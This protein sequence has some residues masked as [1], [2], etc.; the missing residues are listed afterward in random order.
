LY[1]DQRQGAE[2]VSSA[3]SLVP[4]EGDDWRQRSLESREVL[5]G[6][7]RRL[8]V[9]EAV[10]VGPN[11]RLLVWRWYSI[12]GSRTASPVWAKVIETREKLLFRRPL[13][14]G[15]LAFTEGNDEELGRERLEEFLVEGL[16]VIA[17]RLDDLSP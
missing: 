7:S 5:L 8:A 15:V 14:A 11:G 13:A 16:P 9:E 6:D 2:L 4:R 17:S 10:L 12:A 1:G 3:N